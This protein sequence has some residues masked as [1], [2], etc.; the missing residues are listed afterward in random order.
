[1]SIDTALANSLPSAAVTEE[2]G[3]SAERFEQLMLQHQRRV[4]RVIYLLV[5]DADAADTLTQE[6]FLRAYQKRKGFRGECKVET[7]LL[8]IAVNLVRDHGKNRRVSFWR[9]LIQ[10]DANLPDPVS[11]GATPEAALLAKE[12]LQ[13]VW[14]AVNSLSPQQRTIFFLRFSEEMP[15]AEIAALL[16]I[17]TGTVKAQLARATGKLRELKEKQWK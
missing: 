7:W 5:R 12:E 13:T 2:E 6:C 14:S 3:I 10:G 16:E 17:K 4:Y 15:L 9:R 1:M 11:E 8:R